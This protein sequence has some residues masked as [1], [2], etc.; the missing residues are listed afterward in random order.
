MW[1]T[2]PLTAANRWPPLLKQHYQEIQEE[3]K[4]ERQSS[5]SGGYSW[6]QGETM[7]RT[8]NQGKVQ[9]GL[10]SGWH[11]HFHYSCSSYWPRC[12]RYHVHESW[13][14]LDQRIEPSFCLQKKFQNRGAIPQI[15]VLIP[16]VTSGGNLMGYCLSLLLIFPGPSQSPN[17]PSQL[18]LR[19]CDN[20]LFN[21]LKKNYSTVTERTDHRWDLTWFGSVI[22][23]GGHKRKRIEPTY[24]I[25]L[26]GELDFFLSHQNSLRQSL[27]LPPQLC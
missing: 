13:R 5:L 11:L 16:Q 23:F 15:T 10:R 9:I 1:I 12:W 14:C 18:W 2:F 26:V 22:Y 24:S 19:F 21:A 25:S 20:F 3:S 27:V 6:V 8:G 7:R 4:N 17:S